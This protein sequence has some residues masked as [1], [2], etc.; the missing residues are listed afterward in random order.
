MRTLHGSRTADNSIQIARSIQHQPTLQCCKTRSAVLRRRAQLEH[1]RS[2]ATCHLYVILS[3]VTY[4]FHLPI[5][6]KPPKHKKAG[7]TLL[8]S[9]CGQSSMKKHQTVRSE[10]VVSAD[11]FTYTYA[12]GRRSDNDGKDCAKNRYRKRAGRAA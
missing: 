3:F 8:A 2:T 1:S 7:L 12:T 5:S 10:Q 6:P 9:W 4:S 11:L